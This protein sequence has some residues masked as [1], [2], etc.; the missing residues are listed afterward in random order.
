MTARS[1]EIRYLWIDAACIIQDDS[2]DWERESEKMGLVYTNAYVTIGALASSSC[3]ESFLSRRNSLTFEWNST[4]KPSIRGTYCLRFLRRDGNLWLPDSK[5]SDYDHSEWGDRAWT[6]QEEKLSTRLLLFGA[7]KITLTCANRQSVEPFEEKELDLT[8]EL[9][10]DDTSN[11]QVV[12]HSQRRIF[13]ESWLDM[14]G[15][16]YS[17]HS[18]TDV[19][20]TFPAVSGIAKRVATATGDLHIAGLW[21]NYL[22]RGLEWKRA[23]QEANEIEDL[24]EG[25]ERSRTYLCPSWSW[26][27][28]KWS[29]LLMAPELSYYNYRSECEIISAWSNLV[30]DLNIFGR[31]K[32]AELQ[33]KGREVR[34]PSDLHLQKEFELDEEPEWTVIMSEYYTATC[35][36]D[37][38]GSPDVIPLQGKLSMLLL[39]SYSEDGGKDSRDSLDHDDN[40]HVLGLLLHPAKV[41]GKYIR[42][43]LF[44]SMAHEGGLRAFQNYEYREMHII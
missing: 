32:Y 24:I 3:H 27:A 30:S 1:L 10:L 9:M 35:S 31:I 20:D 41:D 12:P 29:I 23:I 33:I 42:V 13:Y 7:S 36:L 15:T 21:K 11:G 5:G 28:A 18:I 43:G 44:R 17:G 8:P 2:G 16:L 39:S 38:I 26:A 6:L 14:I 40:R 25:V 22:P 4:L 37:W 19:H 34:L